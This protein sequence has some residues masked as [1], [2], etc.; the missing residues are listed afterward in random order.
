MTSRKRKALMDDDPQSEEGTT[1]TREVSELPEVDTLE[2]IV[3]KRKEE[4]IAPRFVELGIDRY[5]EPKH[6]VDYTRLEDVDQPVLAG[7]SVPT[8]TLVL[9]VPAQ[10][11][12]IV[13]AIYMATSSAPAVGLGVPAHSMRLI[14]LAKA[15]VM[16][17][18]DE[19]QAYVKEAIET[20]LVPQKENLEAAR[21]ELKIRPVIPLDTSAK[22][23]PVLEIEP[24]VQTATI[25]D[26]VE[27]VDGDTT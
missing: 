20:T 18:V 19:F 27:I 3:Q 16:K 26:P 12:E 25:A 1:T 7:A 17:L 5:I 4:K 6:M 10:T 8:S 11:I 15:K 9:E 23:A 22:L 2:E 14:R 13:P 24:A 21:E